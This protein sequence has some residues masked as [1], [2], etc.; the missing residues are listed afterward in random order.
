M[1]RLVL[2]VFILIYSYS[3]YMFLFLFILICLTPLLTKKYE[4]VLKD[5][6][7]SLE[8]KKEALRSHKY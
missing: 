6:K 2:Y 5:K 4:A 1:P 7:T 8:E 3:F